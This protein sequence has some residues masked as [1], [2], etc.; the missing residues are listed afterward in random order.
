MKIKVG[1]LGFV[2]LFTLHILL[3]HEKAFSALQK[4]NLGV[5][6]AQVRD[7]T[8]YNNSGTTEILIAIDSITG[9]YRWVS[10][11][12]SS[13]QAVTYPTIVG[14]ASQIE[15]NLAP[16]YE[17]DIYTII[18]ETSSGP[19]VYGNDSGGAS[20]SW[21][22]ISTPITNP[23]ILL[24]HSSGMHIGTF[25][26]DI[27]RST[28]G[29]T[30][31]F[32]LI[33]SFGSGTEITSISVYDANTIFV[34]TRTS[35]STV[36]LYKLVSSG[37]SIS[38]TS[39]TLP[40]SSASG[41]LVEIHLVGVDPANVDTI[42]IAGSSVNPQVYKSVDG[43]ITW[44]SSWDFTSTGTNNFSGGYP[45]YI[46]FSNNNVF[47][48][49][50]VLDN[51]SAT[52]SHAPILSSVVGSYTVETHVNDGALKIDPVDPAIVYMGTDWG[53][54]Q[55]TYTSGSW[56][57]GSEI[58][59]N[60]GIEGVVLNDMEF[61]EYSSTS[62]E[63]WIA[64]KSGAGRANN[65]DPTDSTTTDDP[66]DWNFPIYPEVDG[67]PVT[68]VAIHPT[69]SSVVF[70]GNNAGRVY[71]TTNGT[72]ASITWTKVFQTE[73]YTSVFGSTRPDHSNITSIQ[74]VPSTPNRMYLSGYNWETGTDGGVYY[75]DDTGDSW[76]E[77]TSISGVPVNTLWV[78]DTT[79]WAGVGS[80]ASSETGLRA[81]TSVT[82]A[83]NWWSPSTGL[84]LDN[85]IVKSIA[86][87]TV[88]DYM[89]VY[90]ATTGGVYKGT[91]YIPTSSGFS[92]WSWTSLTSAIG[93][94]NTDFTSVTLDPNN[95]D[96]AYAAAGNCIY[97]TTDGG[98]TWPVF[99]TSC[100]STYEDV[101]V[102]KFDDLMAGTAIGLFS[103]AS[104]G[105]PTTPTPLSSPVPTPLSSPTPIPQ[106]SPAIK[107]KIS[108]TIVDTEGNPI[109]SVRVRLK[110]IRT[111]FSS[112][113]LSNTN[114]S[115]EFTDLN[116]G[117]YMIFTKKKGYKRSK[118]KIKLKD[119]EVKTDV[120]IE[121]KK[122]KR[123]V[124]RN[125]K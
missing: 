66:T 108:G 16:G 31:S 100:S 72:S 86:G 24:G 52:W 90:V 125:I 97:E 10:G 107:G 114:G 60:E 73:D 56:T 28:G 99:G 37:S 18:T 35:G 38:S 47:V 70:V 116:E 61:Y 58:G 91:L 67:P 64:A 22:G 19:Q 122:L 53:I 45:Q 71:K 34:V 57:T 23:N 17:N 87:T 94:T 32:D 13:W 14:K 110:G 49:A 30:D 7:I 20:G 5:Y 25:N 59:N 54:G 119:G 98:V 62:K 121:L 118:Q 3:H 11:S 27:Y 109:D 93:S 123:G 55:M 76:T 79:T 42:F 29:V 96:T 4:V 2:F 92:S 26:G 81:R 9:V 77:D 50:S 44:I 41:G 15:A 84:S 75:S 105:S 40:T 117:T 12:S 68:E 80:S 51:T 111:K 103:F 8:A 43:G 39:L 82:G 78:T 85:E 1:I 69:D 89:T 6:G 106:S 33:Y 101:N 120:K 112:A 104:D 36:S 102:L 88:G 124:F 95:P 46:E 63:L 48:S 83:G 115:F 113:T 65:F 21:V 74:F